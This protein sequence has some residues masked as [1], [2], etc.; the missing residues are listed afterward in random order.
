MPG[1]TGAWMNYLYYYKDGKYW[2]IF[3]PSDSRRIASF[4]EQGWFGSISGT[5][6]AESFELDYTDIPTKTWAAY[7]DAVT[8]NAV[9]SESK[10][11]IV[12]D[13]CFLGNVNDDFLI[14]VAVADYDNSQFGSHAVLLS[15]GTI[16][17]TDVIAAV[18]PESDPLWGPV[19]V[20][21]LAFAPSFA[22]SY[23]GT[24]KFI[25]AR[26]DGL[27]GGRKTVL[28][29]IDPVTPAFRS[30]RIDADH[31]FLFCVT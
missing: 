17:L 4:D 25:I 16:L 28:I 30:R 8:T 31:D 24:H 9:V 20:D 3:S 12:E 21:F 22:A 2:S 5:G 29:S 27:T 13:T 10:V 7:Q 26:N 1:V 19:S 6:P 14:D 11:F 15:S 18:F 23:D